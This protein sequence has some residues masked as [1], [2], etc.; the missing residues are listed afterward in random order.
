MSRFRALAISVTF[1]LCAAVGLLL[2]L[3]AGT[4]ANA[5]AEQSVVLGGS[6][7]TDGTS[8]SAAAA[9]GVRRALFTPE[10][11]LAVT[12]DH[13]KRFRCAIANNS[14]TILT[15]FGSPCAAPGAALSLYVTDIS[16]SASVIATVTA[17]Q[18]LSVKFGTGGTC[19]T[20]T[21]TL[22]SAYNLAFAPVEGHFRTPLK[23]TANNELC[24]MHAA[25]GSKTFIVS[26]YIAP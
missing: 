16:A 21:T 12:Q 14:A 4:R 1:V 8:P 5:Q 15:A 17:D 9:G 18:Y 11:L 10:G 13:P 22:W 6:T 3:A 26:G 2:S 7:W 25:V 19:G 24:W 20:G 23:V